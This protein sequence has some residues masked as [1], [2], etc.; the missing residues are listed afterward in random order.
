ML[1]LKHLVRNYRALIIVSL[2]TNY[3]SPQLQQISSNISDSCFLIESFVGNHESIASEFKEFCGFFHIQKLSCLGTL[4]SFRPPGTKFGLKRDRRKLH[5]E[6]LHLPPEES[7]AMVSD[8]E[9]FKTSDI[10]SQQF[11]S[12]LTTTSNVSS[13][14][15]SL[16]LM[17]SYESD[18]KTRESVINN[19]NQ[20][21]VIYTPEEKPISRVSQLAAK[22]ATNVPKGSSVSISQVHFRN[23]MSSN[24]QY[25]F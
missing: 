9:K 8:T 2:P 25:D 14:S 22:F 10:T 5:I 24:N 23:K 3:T 11:T 1:K 4:T 15:S 7:R 13:S 17:L 18:T 16:N 19:S 12:S 6:P 20:Q 21:N